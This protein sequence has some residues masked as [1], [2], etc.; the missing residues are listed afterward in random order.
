MR[1]CHRGI[2]RLLYEM[3]EEAKSNGYPMI[4]CHCRFLVLLCLR[5]CKA[6]RPRSRAVVASV[7]ANHTLVQSV[8]AFSIYISAL[9]GVKPRHVKAGPTSKHIGPEM[10]IHLRHLH[11]G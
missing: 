5:P 9:T 7:V 4:Q 11:N 3:L 1:T 10:L 6:V 2:R 8:C